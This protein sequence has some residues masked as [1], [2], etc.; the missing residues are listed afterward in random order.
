MAVQP[1]GQLIVAGI[2]KPDG[3]RGNNSDVVVLRVATDG[4]LDGNF[5]TGGKAIANY[6]GLNSDDDCN[7]VA[8]QSDGKIVIGGAVNDF[9]TSNLDK[10]LGLLLMR[11]TTTGVLDV[12]FDGDGKAAANISPTDDDQALVVALN[13][14]RIYLAGYSGAPRDLAIAAFKNDNITLPIVLTQFYAQK[15]SSNVVLQWTTSSE[16]N[17]AQF[18][19][20]RSSDGKAFKTIGTVAATGNSSISKNYSFTDQSPFT[21]SDNYYRLRVQD[22]DG[23]ITYSKIIIIKFSAGL[24]T[25]LQV[26]PNRLRAYCR[27][28][29]LVV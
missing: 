10:A 7:S 3:V 11:F 5:G 18:V 12:N 1:D 20:E 29:Y 22:L 21:A 13:G 4:S 9:P 26:F 25:Q 14:D 27:F 15:Q 24:T 17:V 23:S 16:K 6:K 8:L 2:T 28:N 19:V